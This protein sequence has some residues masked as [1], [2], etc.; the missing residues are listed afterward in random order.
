[1]REILATYRDG[2]TIGPDMM[3]NALKKYKSHCK[4]HVLES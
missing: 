2:E 1:M 3:Q 4:V